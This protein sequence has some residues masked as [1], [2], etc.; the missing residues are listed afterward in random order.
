MPGKTSRGLG[1]LKLTVGILLA[2]HAASQLFSREMWWFIGNVNLIFHEAGHMFLMFFGE[3]L[4]YCGGWL[5]ELGIP[6]FV[7]LYFAWK[8][9]FFSAAVTSWWLVTAALSIS[10]Y[11]S[12]ARERALPLLG[13]DSIGHDWYNIL[14]RLGLLR[15]DDTVGY[16]FWIFGFGAVIA[17]GWFL[18]RD[19]DIRSVIHN[20]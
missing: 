7:T 13:G 15:Y 1:F 18:S 11:A 10:I 16:G 9:Q 17:L 8:Q 6:L 2:G 12:D 20:K 3:L 19:L 4:M 14:S 5:F